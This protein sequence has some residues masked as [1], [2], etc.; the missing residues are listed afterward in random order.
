MWT[1]PL[2][3]RISTFVVVALGGGEGWAGRTKAD[4][5]LSGMRKKS[6]GDQSSV[7]AVKCLLCFGRVRPEVLDAR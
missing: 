3:P 2:F 5:L 1:G 6:A 4:L 7:L